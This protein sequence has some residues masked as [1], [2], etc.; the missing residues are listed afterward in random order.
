M[1]TERTCPNCENTFT[2]VA[3]YCICPNCNCRF[4]A[5]DPDR[6]TESRMP[7]EL[8]F[9]ARTV[10][11]HDD[12]GIL[13]ICFDDNGDNYVL[14]TRVDDEHMHEYDDRGGVYVEVNSQAIASVDGFKSV[15]LESGRLSI[16]F[17]DSKVMKG[18]LTLTVNFDD[19]DNFA[20]LAEQ[21]AI[22]MRG[23]E[24]FTTLP[25]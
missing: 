5:S 4:Y 23:K 22:L 9:N 2:A 11:S 20:E 21:F 19:T 3:D 6:P 7:D 16:N 17:N 13:N 25:T 24:E 8:S 10:G 18:L 15:V 14:L 12:E 1:N